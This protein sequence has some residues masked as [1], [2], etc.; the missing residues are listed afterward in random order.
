M[1]STRELVDRGL[2]IVAELERLKVEKKEIDEEL[3]K[4]GLERS[5][6]HVDLKDEDREGKRWLAAG[7]EKIVPVVFTADKLVG[8]FAKGSPVHLKILNAAEDQLQTFFKRVE[9]FE[10]RF[11][12][13]KKFRNIAREIL[14]DKAPAFITACLARDKNGV[15]KS[16]IKIEWDKAEVKI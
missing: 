11:D 15:P 6:E 8:S 2:Q 13:G 3:E 5:A 10:N 12:N 4:R 1:K 16:D 14:G 9:G 7:S